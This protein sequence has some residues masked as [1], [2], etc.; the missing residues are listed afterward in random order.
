MVG[1]SAFVSDF[2]ELTVLMIVPITYNATIPQSIRRCCFGVINY[3]A[4]GSQITETECCVWWFL[5]EIAFTKASLDSSQFLSTRDTHR[6]ED[7][8]M[9]YLQKKSARCEAILH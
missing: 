7:I 9:T 1:A 5:K 3:A 6:Q 2:I 8:S 4:S